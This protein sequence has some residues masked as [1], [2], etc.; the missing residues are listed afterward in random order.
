MTTTLKELAVASVRPDPN[1]PRSG[2]LDVEDLVKSIREIGLIEPIVVRPIGA[3][4]VVVAGHRRLAAIKKLGGDWKT[5]TALVVT[6]YD[7]VGALRDAVAENTVRQALSAV[8]EANAMVQLSGMGMTD[9]E[10][11]RTFA[12][13][14]K[15]VAAAKAIG[16]ASDKGTKALAG[17]KPK[18]GV[19]LTIEQAAAVA[20]FGG[21]PAGKQL[22]IEIESGSRYWRSTYTELVRKEAINED[23]KAIATAHKGVKKVTAY[24]GYYQGPAKEVEPLVNLTD[25]K[26][27]KLTLTTHKTCLGHAY[28]IEKP[29]SMYGTSGTKCKVA[30]WCTDWKANGHKVSATPKRTWRQRGKETQQSN[31]KKGP[32]AK[33]VEEERAFDVAWD[34]ATARRRVFIEEFLA[35]PKTGE[36]WTLT[37]IRLLIT[38]RFDN[39]ENWETM[40]LKALVP[41]LIKSYVQENEDAYLDDWRWYHYHKQRPIALLNFLAANGHDLSDV[42]TKAIERANANMDWQTDRA[43]DPGAINVYITHDDDDQDDDIEDVET[44]DAL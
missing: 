23:A 2:K 44:G 12:R 32:S 24:D 33:V 42:E 9:D 7:D 3:Q 34:E 5:I 29:S 35:K 19:Q 11:A 13:D 4:F 41:A 28:S 22:M 31:A 20:Q 10:I 39:P 38:E 27:K 15:T 37:A 6:D 43:P 36:A 26:G 21:T 25:A 8:D 18:E 16:T 14:A 1:N 30:Y 17:V 40:G